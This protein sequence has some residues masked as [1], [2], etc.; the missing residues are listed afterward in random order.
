MNRGSGFMD[1]DMKRLNGQWGREGL[2][3]N[4]WKINAWPIM[5]CSDDCTRFLA[6]QF[7]S[8]TD[9]NCS[10]WNHML[11]W[12]DTSHVLKNLLMTSFK[13]HP[14]IHELRFAFGF[15]WGKQRQEMI[16]CCRDSRDWHRATI[17][18]S[19]IEYRDVVLPYHRGQKGNCIYNLAARMSS[20]LA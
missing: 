8:D 12:S 1:S 17:W 11:S 2:E 20:D 13:D 15:Y 14:P 7:I 4:T 9:A 5:T 16:R 10:A 18:W 6:L 3:H 19:L